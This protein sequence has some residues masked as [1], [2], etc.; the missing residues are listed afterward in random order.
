[1]QYT[2]LF[3]IHTLHIVRGPQFPDDFISI[4]RSQKAST[5][6]KDCGVFLQTHGMCLT[7]MG[8]G[9]FLGFAPSTSTVKRQMQ[10]LA[11]SNREN[12]GTHIQSAHEEQKMAIIMIDDFHNILTLKHPTTETL[13]RADHF[14]TCLVNTP[15]V[16]AIHKVDDMHRVVPHQTSTGTVNIIGGICPETVQ[17]IMVTALSE[18]T[19]ST[20]AMLP[21]TFTDIDSSKWYQT[22]KALQVY[23][24]AAHPVDSTT[25]ST[26]GLA[27]LIIMS[28]KNKEDY[29]KVF[30][31]MLTTPMSEYLEEYASPLVAD[32]PG[33]YFTKHLIA[34]R[35]IP[36]TIIPRQGPFHVYLNI[37]EDHVQMSR[38][39]YEP[40]FKHIFGVDLPLR[41]KLFRC[42]LV[43]T[44]A[45]L[46]WKLIRKEIIALFK[47]SRD[48][49]YLC[50]YNILEEVLPIVVLHYPVIFKSGSLGVYRSAMRRLGLLFMIWKRHH[51]DRATLSWLSGDQYHE[52]SFQGYNRRMSIWN[53]NVTDLLIEI[54]HA[55]L[56]RHI[57]PHFDAKT[58]RN[59]ALTLASLMKE[60]ED[61]AANFGSSPPSSSLSKK[62]FQVIE[63]KAAD[64]FLHTFDKVYANAGMAS[65]TKTTTDGQPKEISL[66]SLETTVDMR[67]MPAAFTFGSQIPLAGSTCDFASCH[68]AS[69]T[70]T[71]RLSCG[72]SY[73]RRCLNGMPQKCCHLCLPGIQKRAKELAL[74]FNGQLAKSSSKQSTQDAE[75]E[76]EDSL[77]TQDIADED[78]GDPLPTP[79]DADKYLSPSFKSSLLSRL[80]SMRPTPSMRTTSPTPSVTPL[81]ECQRSPT[82]KQPVQSVTVLS[83]SLSPK[84]VR[85]AVPRT[86]SPCRPGQSILA[87]RAQNLI[88]K[89]TFMQPPRGSE[90]MDMNESTLDEVTV[91]VFPPWF[92]LS[93]ISG[94]EG[95]NACSI[96]AVLFAHKYYGML[97]HQSFD[98]HLIYV[99]LKA[100]M[101][102]GNRRHDFAYSGRAFNLQIDEAIQLLNLPV[103]IL[104]DQANVETHRTSHLEDETQLL[105]WH[106]L[107]L[108]PHNREAAFFMRSDSTVAILPTCDDHIV[109]V[110]SHLHSEGKVGAIVLACKK[111]DITRL[112]ECYEEVANQNPT[113]MGTVT[114]A[115][116]KD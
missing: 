4:Y 57:Q 106:L 108:S 95:S 94:R 107:N 87:K 89:M 81:M 35:R 100:A 58:V 92:S 79:T 76:A 29:Y 69:T 10:Q 9:R 116:M 7:E 104:T 63:R 102:D 28:L 59:R 54:F 109:L 82:K 67:S 12:F 105:E 62:D 24:I 30:M 45:F 64:F 52:E 50:L 27:D 44:A 60:G 86:S 40:M 68:Q 114:I 23:E 96:I 18:H 72:H 70:N 115:K 112:I 80:N 74:A 47:T 13:S 16:P 51:Y 14:A 103:T 6:Q 56:R 71:L 1:M 111:G 53:P 75:D 84:T 26:C 5:L 43:V 19:N 83:P 8:V 93:T 65:V 15:G 97:M 48:L 37:V 78:D 22:M 17:D 85:I 20:F 32:W 91:C 113:R 41:P 3:L 55:K 11:D 33:W 73:H 25:L 90:S 38:C 66:P 99:G 42:E 36:P 101:K 88:Q 21:T 49:E 34:A 2:V 46:G 31:D 77:P 98:I 39:I 110:D 61:F